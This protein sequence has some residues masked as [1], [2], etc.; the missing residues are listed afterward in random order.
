MVTPLYGSFHSKD[1]K[2]VY[3]FPFYNYRRS[4]SESHFSILFFLVRH[5]QGPGYSRTSVLWPICERVKDSTHRSFRIAPV[6]WSARTD[7][8]SMFSIQPFFYKYRSSTR[9]T[10]I[11]S[12]FLY[13]REEITGASVMNSLLFRAWYSKKFSNGD[14]EKRFLHLVY[15]DVK[16]K[17]AVEKGLLPF[18]HIEKDSTGN[19]S[20]SVLFGLYSHFREYKPSISDFYE[21]E[22]IFWFIRVRSNYKQLKSEGKGDFVK[23]RK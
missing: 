22:R 16:E 3:L 12:W 13:K 15:T 1:H 4:G 9:A 20:F 5:T 11:L 14:H 17:G 19:R 10:F 23:K 21:E 7:T 2:N 6:I 8:S 18:Y